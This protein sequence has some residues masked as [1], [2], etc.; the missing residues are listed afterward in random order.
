MPFTSTGFA[1]ASARP[2]CFQI[3]FHQ[4]HD[5]AL[6]ARSTAPIAVDAADEISLS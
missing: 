1:V 6:V 3:I 4:F 5:E 2:H